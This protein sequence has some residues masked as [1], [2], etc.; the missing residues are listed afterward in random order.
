M[1]LCLQVF[2]WNNLF[3]NPVRFKNI[4]KIHLLI[5]C[6]ILKLDK[7]VNKIECY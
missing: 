6:R 2:G 5:S 4:E 1:S 3:D 7:R